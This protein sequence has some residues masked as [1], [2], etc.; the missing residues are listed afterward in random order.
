VISA[1]RFIHL[2]ALDEVCILF[3]LPSLLLMNI[4]FVSF[5]EGKEANLTASN[6]VRKQRERPKSQSLGHLE[7]DVAIHRGACGTLGMVI[8]PLVCI[9]SLFWCCSF[10]LLSLVE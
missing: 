5:V 3:Y 9:S 10:F 8:L 6:S 1:Y 7:L 2:F 4:T